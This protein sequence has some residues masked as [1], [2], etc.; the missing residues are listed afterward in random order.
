V[1]NTFS[2]SLFF[3]YVLLSLSLSL[4]HVLFF[5]RHTQLAQLAFSY[6][7][8]LNTSFEVIVPKILAG[9]IIFVIYLKKIQNVLKSLNMDIIYSFGDSFYRHQPRDYEKFPIESHNKSAQGK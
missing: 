1:R 4:S 5:S 3:F 2:L 7:I 6:T 8:T 9:R